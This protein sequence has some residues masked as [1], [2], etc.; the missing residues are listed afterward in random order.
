MLTWRYHM[1]SLVGIFLALGLGLLIGISLS[2]NGVVD[3]SQA[4]LVNNIQHDLS[5]LR[6]QNIALGRDNAA[7]VRYQD[8]TFPFIVGGR[9]QGKK[10]ALV[11]T[12][13][14]GDDL[15]RKA[16]SAIHGA[17]G[18]V[19]STTVLNPR[20][21]NTALTAKLKS[22][23]KSDPAYAAANES[24]APSLTSQLLAKELSGRAGVPKGLP[25]LQGIAVDSVN[26]SYETPVD[27]VV[28]V[29]RADDD[30]TP[31]WA[32]LEKKLLLNLKDMG[33]MTVGSEP[34][35][36]PLSEVPLFL[37]VDISSVDNLD[38]RIGQTSLVYI[39]SGEKGAFG[40]KTTADM[41]I[42]IL[43]TPKQAVTTPTP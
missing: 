33:V 23:L 13:K 11:A 37:S 12:S 40:I 27:A 42:P 10:I 9:L 30:H 18:Q 8:D 38:S 5:D 28:Y 3:T 41:L 6:N 15:L 19:V 22:D 35:D 16:S 20:L 2:D 21:D 24:S 14:A 7:N 43:R 32:D 39:L 1:L 34:A 17:G 26:G 4:G 29:T 31:A 25:A 36:A